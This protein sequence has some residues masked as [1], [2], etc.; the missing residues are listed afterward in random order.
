MMNARPRII[1]R[2]PSVT[3][4]GGIFALVAKVPF[5]SPHTHPAAIPAKKEK[6]TGTFKNLASDAAVTPDS[7][8]VDPTERS[9]PPAITTKVSPKAHIPI[10]ETCLR[11]TMKL[12]NVKK[13]PVI[14]EK[15]IIRATR[16]TYIPILSI[17]KNLFTP[18]LMLK[19]SFRFEVI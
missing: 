4:I 5:R 13:A 18:P 12:S 3:I 10:I 6:G 2:V 14:K 1:V 11:I 15:N 19:L 16:K 17:E 7:A 8:T 9:I